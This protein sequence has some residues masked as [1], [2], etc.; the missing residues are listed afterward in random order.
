MTVVVAG[1]GGEIHT[2][3]DLAFIAGATS[4]LSSL[5]QNLSYFFAQFVADPGGVLGA[6][7]PD[8]TFYARVVRFSVL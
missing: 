8:H 3:L 5:L 7:G 6:I 1:I 2:G 4:V